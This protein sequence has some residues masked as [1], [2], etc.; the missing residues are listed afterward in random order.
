MTQGGHSIQFSNQNGSNS[1]KN[2]N[3]K[4]INFMN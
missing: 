1:N 3:A 2:K 4:N